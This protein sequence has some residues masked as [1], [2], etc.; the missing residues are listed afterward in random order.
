MYE[1][2]DKSGWFLLGT[3]S[4]EDNSQLFCR[5]CHAKIPEQINRT[6]TGQIPDTSDRSVPTQTSVG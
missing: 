2:W 1:G 4:N 6:D 5:H 3:A